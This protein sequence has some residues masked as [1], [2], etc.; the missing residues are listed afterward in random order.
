M[1]VDRAIFD[2]DVGRADQVREMASNNLSTID[3]AG[4]FRADFR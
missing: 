3:N 1:L 2:N 4:L